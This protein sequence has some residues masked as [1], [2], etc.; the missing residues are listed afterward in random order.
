MVDSK[1]NYKFDLGVNIQASSGLEPM[2]PQIQ[3]LMLIEKSYFG[4]ILHYICSVY[5]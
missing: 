4:L 5:N 1:E 3:L 2:P